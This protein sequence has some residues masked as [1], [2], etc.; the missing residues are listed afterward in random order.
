MSATAPKTVPPPAATSSDRNLEEEQRALT[1]AL[2]SHA[3]PHVRL[4]AHI[5][6]R[7]LSFVNL[8]NE[9]RKE[10]REGMAAQT[11]AIEELTRTVNSTRE[12]QDE[13]ERQYPLS[14]GNGEHIA[15][16]Q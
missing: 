16:A 13:H 15:D 7:Q 12:R 5:S 4:I 1:L 11:K 8:L 2:T 6:E 9:F 10:V 14:N 3:D